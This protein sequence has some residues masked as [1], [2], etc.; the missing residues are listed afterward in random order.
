MNT[1]DVLKGHECSYRYLHSVF[2][3]EICVDASDENGSQV[4]GY[5]I[6]FAWRGVGSARWASTDP[7]ADEHRVCI[8]GII[9][10]VYVGVVSDTDQTCKSILALDRK[11]SC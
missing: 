6:V 1:A 10:S 11:T 9:R 2:A 5:W 3:S 8:F 7:S 4:P